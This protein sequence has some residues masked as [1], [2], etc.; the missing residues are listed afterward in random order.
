MVMHGKPAVRRMAVLALPLCLLLLAAGAGCGS[1]ARD[2]AREARSSY[3]SA[4]AVLVGV[5]EFPA[6]MEMLLRSGDISA[7]KARASGLIV[8]VRELL[9]IA[10]S[11]FETVS[12]N[13]GQLA[14][15]G[16]EK[17]AIY[18][19]TL[20]EL[21][22]MNKQVISSYSEFIGLSNSVLAGLPYGEDPDSL[23]PTLDYMDEVAARIRDLTAR[24]SALEEEAETL[25]QDLTLWGQ[26]SFV[27]YSTTFGVR[28]HLLRIGIR[29]K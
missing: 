13:S 2:L 3:I 17:F 22:E 15:E 21:S 14:A 26:S 10:S 16:G 23:M 18:A 27:A 7:V 1:N 9:P 12:Q 4:R 19:D 24:I 20:L 5:E 29:N 8:D 6:Q 25:Y 28:A 11:A